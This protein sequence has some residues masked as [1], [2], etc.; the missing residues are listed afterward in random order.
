MS[1]YQLTNKGDIEYHI[2]MNNKEIIFV[3]QS[4]NN[5]YK[6]VCINEKDVFDGIIKIGE[7]LNNLGE[8]ETKDLFETWYYKYGGKNAVINVKTKELINSAINNNVEKRIQCYFEKKLHQ[9]F[10]I[11][12]FCYI[13]NFKN[14]PNI[15]LNF[16]DF[17]PKI[18]LLYELNNII[19][20]IKKNKIPTS[21][22]WEF[23]NKKGAQLTTK[24]IYN[25]C[26]DIFKLNFAICPIIRYDSETNTGYYVFTNL[27]DIAYFYFLS[28]II[29]YEDKIF[30]KIS[31]CN[32]CHHIFIDYTGTTLYC[33]ECK[34]ES[35]RRNKA[36]SRASLSCDQK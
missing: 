32:I 20:S 16:I 5:I 3:Q 1:V 17:M 4:T 7:Y 33:K 19:T 27:I 12:N 21:K 28:K 35:I 18:Y 11:S 30:S 6:D 31:I 22:I 13:D 29:T 26:K 36:N 14:L 15:Q 10:K 2:D 34:P 24:E 23:T 9:L 8:V 25:I